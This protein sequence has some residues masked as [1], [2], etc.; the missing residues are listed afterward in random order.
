MFAGAARIYDWFVLDRPILT[1]LLILG[2]VGLLGVHAPD[3]KLDASADTLILEND[4]AL[5]YYRG[6]KARYGSDDFLVL[7]YTPRADLFSDVAL[8][9]LRR[10]RA[11]LTTIERVESVV[12][13]LDVPLIDSP[14]VTL[15]QLTEG[16]RTL[17][18]PGMDRKLARKELVS[19]PLYRNLVISP[20]GK[21]TALQVNFRQ[22]ETYHRLMR[23]RDSLREMSLAAPLTPGQAAR[24]E[25]VVHQFKLH[26]DSLLAQQDKDIARVREIMQ[27][28]QAN[29]QMHLG[30]VP[31]IVADSIAYVRN[32]IEVFGLGVLAFVIVIMF[33][34][35]RKPRWVLLPMLTCSATVI[36]MV[37]FLG[38]ADWRVTVVSSNFISLLLIITLS[39]TVYLIV[40]YREAYTENP[41]LDQ[42]ALVREAVHSK[43]RPCFYTA[44]TTMVGFGS[45]IVSD[46]RPV[47]DFGWMMVV[48]ITLALS[49][50]FTLFPAS[51]MLFSPD[52]TL[53]HRDLTA[54]I[55]GFFARMIEKYAIGTLLLFAALVAI[56]ASGIT[57]LTVENRFID[58]YKPS[59]EIYQGMLL[60]DK[61]LGGTTPMDV[62]ID[63]PPDPLVEGHGT[64]P[65]DLSDIDNSPMVT[66]ESY[67][68][69]SFM[70]EQ[71]GAIH[72][73]LEGLPATG[74]VLSLHTTMSML[75]Q[76]NEK[77]VVDD[78]FLAI[79]YKRLPDSIRKSMFEPYLS[80]D[81]NQLRYSVRVFES[82]P[83]LHRQQLID[84][85]KT[86]LV[87]KVGLNPEQIHVSGMLVLYNN[88]LQSLFRSQI[89]TLG[90]VFLAILVMLAVLFR[91][92]KLAIIGIIPNMVGAGLVL[93]IMGWL[94][95]PLDIMTITI[96]AISIGI[97]VDQA[98]HYVDR[99]LREFPVDRDYWASLKRCHGSIGRAMYYTA[100]IITLGFSILALSNFVPTIYFGLLTGLAM[101]MALFSNF[102]LLPL[103]LAKLKPMSA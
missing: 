49:L 40:R 100:T 101:L 56:A 94:H 74:K 29:A 48:G 66:G 81:G 6:I 92:L 68:Y 13:L 22:D 7:T 44:I 14:R 33:V 90:M 10:L 19:S 12:S 52:R 24:L 80:K 98:I 60:I 64:E 62:I 72:E 8:A 43:W 50:A 30:G 23:E 47:I 83:N 71:I 31:M 34:A 37:G 36:G 70:L 15:S 102:P 2:L 26:S 88:M 53:A 9:D 89:L 95:I 76:L 18:T 63:A 55:T 87:E 75:E 1:L 3:F 27:G 54:S 86:G 79:L 85:V 32:D 28:H 78:F 11:E 25:T 73:Y 84:Q 57:R 39:L 46:I 99:F 5:E 17:E 35:F 20:D 41:E 93:G 16:V 45:L 51:M 65:V 4:K 97:G 91:S 59:T 69:N 103:L 77:S 21:T 82:D 42:R 61:Q 58:Y 96:A 38:W 67:W